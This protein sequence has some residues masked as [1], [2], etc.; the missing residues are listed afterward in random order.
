MVLGCKTKFKNG[1]AIEEE[2]LSYGA[3]TVGVI[4][5]NGK[6]MLELDLAEDKSFP[7]EFRER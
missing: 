3:F 7:K 1:K 4:T 6:T 5:D 2:I